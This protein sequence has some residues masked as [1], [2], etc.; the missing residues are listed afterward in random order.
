M[1][2]SI[3]LFTVRGIAVRVHAS[4]LLILLWAAYTGLSESSRSDWLRGAGFMVAFVVLLFACVVLHEL[5]HSLVAQLFGVKVQDITLWP[6]GG[7]AR[8]TKLP[9]KPYQEFLITAAGPATNVLLAIG[10]GALALTLI[11]P[12]RVLTLLLYPQLLERFLAQMNVRAL[13]LLLVINNVVLV[14]FNLVPAFPMDGG[15]LLRS[16]LAVFLPFAQATRVASVVGQGLAAVMGVVALLTGNFL[17]AL[18]SL[19]VF[20]AAWQ[21]R[22]QVITGDHLRG[23]RVHQVMQPLGRRLHPLQTL[24]EA[25]ALIAASPQAVYLVVDGGR[26]VGVVGR[27]DLLA[28]IHRAGPTARVLQHMNRDVSRLGPNDLLTEV[29][30]SRVAIVVEGGQVVGTLAPSDL[31]RLAQV[32]DAWPGAM[33]RETRL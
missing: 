26:L 9:E 16:G 5:G 18:V 23:L 29:D 1:S 25:V 4:F 11:G 30:R 8:M 2:W 10:L 20:L 28:A 17:L 21:E 31:A 12:D 15:R 7:V 3:K 19:F 33:G 14:L 22:Q 6:V 24:G 13:L 27:G 32:L